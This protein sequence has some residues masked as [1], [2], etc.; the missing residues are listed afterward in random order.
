LFNIRDMNAYHRGMVTLACIPTAV[1]YFLPLA[2]GKFNELYPNIKVRILEQGT[3]N[4]MESVL[5]NESDFGINM[6]NVTN[7]SIDF[8]PLV[9]EPFV[10]A[11]RRDHPLA[12][13]QLVEWQEL[14][15][16]KMIGVRSSSGNRLLIEQ[17]LADKPWK[18]DWFYEVRHLSTSLGLVEAGLGISALPGLAMPHAPY[19]SIIGIPLV[20]PVIRRTLGIIR[21]KDAVLS[22]AAERFFAL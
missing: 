6:N 8:T 19:S 18:L 10:L 17:Q 1:F 13:K 9:N 16:Y 5:C 3:N 22:P 7:S 15:G 12:K 4:C 11:C 2:I 21:R 20:E 14:V